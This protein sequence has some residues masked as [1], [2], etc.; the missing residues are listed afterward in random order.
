MVVI[1]HRD[2]LKQVPRTIVV[3]CC[4]IFGKINECYFMGCDKF[5]DEVLAPVIKGIGDER[6]RLRISIAAA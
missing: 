4:L 1:E 6:R 5:H 3:T 2:I